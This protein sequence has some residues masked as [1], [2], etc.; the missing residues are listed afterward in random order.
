M[1]Y[2]RAIS[3]KFLYFHALKPVIMMK[4][5]VIILLIA[6][7]GLACKKDEQVEISTEKDYKKWK[8]NVSLVDVKESRCP[9]GVNCIWEGNGEVTFAIKNKKQL[10]T[11]SL[12]TNM[13]FAADT[14]IGQMR[15]TL[16]E[17]KPYPKEGEKI[18]LDK[19]IATLD[20]DYLR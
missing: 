5:S 12:N 15:I 1:Y 20:I 9:E 6:F 11:I 7:V 14:V 16:K 19:Y 13:K 17:L 3:S 10:D 8:L 2:S 4:Y 18:S